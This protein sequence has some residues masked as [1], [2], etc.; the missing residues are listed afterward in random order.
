MK[1]SSKI[2]SVFFILLNL[3]FTTLLA[4][5]VPTPAN[6]NKP[7]SKEQADAQPKETSKPE[8]QKES[9][10]STA[11]PKVNADDAKASK[12]D[13]AAMLFYLDPS[14]NVSL[15]YEVSEGDVHLIV[16]MDH[17]P[18]RNEF[19]FSF[20]HVIQGFRIDTVGL[21]NAHFGFHNLPTALLPMIEIEKPENSSAKFILDE[22]N[23][24]T[25]QRINLTAVLRDLSNKGLLIDTEN[26]DFLVGDIKDFQITVK[27]SN[28]ESSLQKISKLKI[29]SSGSVPDKIIQIYGQQQLAELLELK[30]YEVGEFIQLP[31]DYKIPYRSKDTQW[32]IIPDQSTESYVTY[33]LIANPKVGDQYRIPLSSENINRVLPKLKKG[34]I[35]FDLERTETEITYLMIDDSVKVNPNVLIRYLKNMFVNLQKD[36]VKGIDS[37]A[38]V[39]RSLAQMPFTLR[40][41]RLEVI[42]P[43]ILAAQD[44]NEIMKILMIEQYQYPVI[45]IDSTLQ[46]SK[47]SSSVNQCL[48]FL[49]NPAS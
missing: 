17:N 49:E 33:Q 42:V 5:E 36:E 46:G 37:T 39:L 16:E 27:M 43:E 18:T 3:S 35:W 13:L 2:Q 8:A 11:S 15:G 30:N 38:S 32:I 31:Q 25:H 4:V 19:V 12:P 47:A 29:S 28:S 9:V 45:K 23:F 44:P 48:S 21:G 41:E 22:D 24:R 20:E 6:E 1:I 7:I 26:N 10:T 40:S 14:L 34:Y